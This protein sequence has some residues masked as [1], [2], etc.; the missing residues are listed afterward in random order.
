MKRALI[1]GFGSIGRKHYDIIK[2]LNVFDTISIFTKSKEKIINKLQT[3]KQI[4]QYNPDY[5]IISTPTNEHLQNIKFIEKNFKKKTVLIEKP[6]LGSYKNIKLKNNV[7]FVGYNLRMHPVLNYIKNMIRKY[8]FWEMNIECSSYLPDW[9]KN[10]HYSES[11]S[12]KKKNYGGVLRDLSHEID[13]LY[14]LIGNFNIKSF[15]KKKISNLK[16]ETED[17][18]SFV[19]IYK[20]KII[21]LKLTYLNKFH[22]REISITGPIF[23]LKASLNENNIEYFIGNK[24]KKISFNYSIDKTYEDMHKNIINKKTNNL[25]TVQ[26]SLKVLKLIKKIEK[27]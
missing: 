20:K 14:Y 27:R 17:Y 7:Y 10:I 16:I 21:N 19:G 13:Y 9:R 25:A 6:V 15:I 5:I 11:S 26:S 8:D 24:L 18:F 3:K 2:K 1:L 23:Q 4:I 22:K 12:A